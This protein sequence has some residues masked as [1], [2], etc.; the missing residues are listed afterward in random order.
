[1]EGAHLVVDDLREVDDRL[2][3]AAVIAFHRVN[4]QFG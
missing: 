1:M 4:P 2:V 3:L